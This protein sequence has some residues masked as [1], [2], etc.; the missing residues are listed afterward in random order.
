MLYKLNNIKKQYNNK[1]IL[2]VEQLQL[3][4]NKLIAIVGNSGSGKTTL[5]NILATITRPTNGTVMYLGNEI[6]NNN[7]KQ[8]ENYFRTQVDVIFQNYNLIENLTVYE[9]LSILKK[10][11]KKITNK[12]INQILIDLNIDHIKEKMI[13]K[14]SGGECQ[15]VAIARALLKETNVILADEP[16]GSLDI[17]NTEN[18]IRIFKRLVA[19]ERSVIFVTHDL[20]CASHADIIHVISDGKL[21]ETINGNKQNTIIQLQTIFTNIGIRSD[22]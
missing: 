1:T 10:V 19:N 2:E 11:D 18:I 15:R 20:N 7:S 17:N 8:I 4:A 22:N 3:P 16:T 12:K 21:I 14:L 9:N 13:D 5:L 6:N